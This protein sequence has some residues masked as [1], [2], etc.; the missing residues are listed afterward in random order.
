MESEKLSFY[1]LGFAV[2]ILENVRAVVNVSGRH[3]HFKALNS[4]QW[5]KLMEEFLFYD[6][7]VCDRL[8]FY[9][10]GDQERDT[11]MGEIIGRIAV[12]VEKGMGKELDEKLK[13]LVNEDF[14]FYLKEICGS[15]LHET[16][17]DAYNMRLKEYSPLKFVKDS[18]KDNPA[19]LLYQAFAL[20]VAFLIG[21]PRNEFVKAHIINS[22]AGVYKLMTS[23]RDI[24]DKH[25][26]V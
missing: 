15:P 24:L 25:W 17:V 14:A 4:S 7:H 1:G 8:I 20:K 5:H 12:I 3:E 13:S 11:L 22:A 9:W 26:S 18:D 16:L 19:D 6:L 2:A 23:T 10:F 21:H